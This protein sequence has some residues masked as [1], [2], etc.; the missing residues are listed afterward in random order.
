MSADLMNKVADAFEQ[1]ERP[2]RD[3]G[4]KGL[5]QLA[6]L[7]PH[8]DDPMMGIFVENLVDRGDFVNVDDRD[9]NL[10]SLNPS[11]DARFSMLHDRTWVI[12]HIDEATMDCFFDVDMRN[13]TESNFGFPLQRDLP[14][15]CACSMNVTEEVRRCASSVTFMEHV[16]AP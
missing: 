11:C 1:E 5:S 14:T 12:H 4:D 8:P 13:F 15:L 3:S 9:W 7:I 6:K 2:F 16:H 10:Y